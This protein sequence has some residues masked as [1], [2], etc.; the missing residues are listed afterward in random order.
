[1]ITKTMMEPMI[2]R[3]LAVILASIVGLLMAGIEQWTQLKNLFL[4]S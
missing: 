2:E 4:Q 1:M 3:A